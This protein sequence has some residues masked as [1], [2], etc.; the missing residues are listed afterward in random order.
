MHLGVYECV[1]VCFGAQCSFVFHTDASYFIRRWRQKL[2]WLRMPSWSRTS[3]GDQQVVSLLNG[4]IYLWDLERLYRAL[5]VILCLLVLRVEKPFRFPLLYAKY[6]TITPLQLFPFYFGF[7]S[8]SVIYFRLLPCTRF[9]LSSLFTHS[10]FS[11]CMPPS[12]A[13]CPPPHFYQQ[14]KLT[15]GHW[16]ISIISV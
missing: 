4:T 10:P 16:Q 1:L 6:E 11:S 15:Q 12:G 14:M 8:N 5:T 13:T 3:Y 9:P 7:P 2:S